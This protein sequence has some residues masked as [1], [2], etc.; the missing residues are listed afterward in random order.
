MHLSRRG[1]LIGT[2]AGVGRPRLVAVA[3]PAGAG[4]G[5]VVEELIQSL[6]GRVDGPVAQVCAADR[7]GVALGGE[8]SV[9]LAACSRHR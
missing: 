8:H 5:R 3:G 6:Q 2:L 7:L 9:W 4:R 1:L